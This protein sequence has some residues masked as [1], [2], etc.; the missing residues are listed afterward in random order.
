M[1][2]SSFS[3]SSISEIRK[4][5]ETD[6]EILHIS[7]QSLDWFKGKFTGKPHDLNGNI[8]GFRLRFSQQNQSIS[9]QLSLQILQFSPPWA[10]A[11]AGGLRQCLAAAAALSQDATFLLSRRL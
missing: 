5:N 10:A 11:P 7:S 8:Y 6:I 9:S 4:K 3:T 1:P 2:I